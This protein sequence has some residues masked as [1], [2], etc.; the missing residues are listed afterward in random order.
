MGQLSASL[1]DLI[2]APVNACSFLFQ[3]NTFHTARVVGQRHWFLGASTEWPGVEPPDVEIGDVDVLGEKYPDTA[4][5]L[6]A[7][8]QGRD[9]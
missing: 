6:R 3:V 7:F 9:D 8:Q 4:N 5:D 1:S 2:C